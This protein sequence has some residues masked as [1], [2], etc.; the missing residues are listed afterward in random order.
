MRMLLRG[1]LG[2]LDGVQLVTVREVSMVARLLV[3][4][5]FGVARGFAMMFGGMLMV[6][7]GFVVV[8]MD[9]V[10]AHGD[11]LFVDGG[12]NAPQSS[13]RR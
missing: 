6:L 4:A 10:V 11:L 5:G 13:A 7:R 1:V 8:M 3:V 12:G 9:V 2:V